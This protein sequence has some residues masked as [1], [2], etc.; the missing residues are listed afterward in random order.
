VRTQKP[1]QQ[2]LVQRDERLRVVKM[3]SEGP[4]A[5]PTNGDAA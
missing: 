1:S 5:G 4:T 3:A 2:V